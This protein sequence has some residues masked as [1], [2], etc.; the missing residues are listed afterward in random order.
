MTPRSGSGFASW[1]TVLR[2]H[3]VWAAS[4]A[5][6]LVCFG[7]GLYALANPIRSYSSMEYYVSDRDGR[8]EPST[9][10]TKGGWLC[11][12]PLDPMG[13]FP[14]CGTIDITKFHPPL[15]NFDSGQAFDA[16]LTKANDPKDLAECKT[17][18]IRAEGVEYTTG[19]FDRLERYI[20]AE[21]WALVAGFVLV[22]VALYGLT[23]RKRAMI[24]PVL[25]LSALYVAV[26]LSSVHFL[27]AC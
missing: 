5:T 24:V 12:A 16:W 26:F 1:F 15:P 27:S 11:K 22:I 19:E 3:P 8:P 20:A 14:E 7:F 21:P 13:F 6:G 9:F 10:A 17:I 23:G 18:A 4:L 2:L 25:A